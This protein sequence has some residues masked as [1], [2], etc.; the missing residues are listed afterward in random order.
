[1]FPPA[2]HT[3]NTA[4]NIYPGPS[5]I[6]DV[7]SK[8]NQEPKK[9]TET[10]EAV[11]NS[12]RTG[13]EPEINSPSRGSSAG[14]NV[15]FIPESKRPPAPLKG[16]PLNRCNCKKSKCLKLYCECFS[17]GTMCGPEC[18]CLDCHNQQGE[19][20][21][22]ELVV[23]ETLQKNS[24]AFRPKFKQ[25]AQEDV[26]IHTRG[27]TCKNTECIKSYCECFRAGTGCSRLCK[28][29]NCKNS[30]IKLEDHE[31]PHYYQKTLRKRKKPNL[32]YDLYFN[33]KNPSTGNVEK[34][35]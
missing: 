15:V 10:K 3:D 11:I 23:Q 21:F 22:R 6:N 13:G 5:I 30:Q 20:E 7:S 4:Q 17:R 34:Q 8:Q 27:C 14:R 24:L 18:K 16:E 31:V 12:A 26:K 35:P 28:C 9:M 29:S 25:H 19:K 2:S 1:M 33:S 32:V